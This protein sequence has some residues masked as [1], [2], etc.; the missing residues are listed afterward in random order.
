VKD[1]SHSEVAASK[2]PPCCAP[3]AQHEGPA[4]P[5]VAMVAGSEGRPAEQMILIRDG[6]FLMGSDD[7]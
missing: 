4:E 2:R 3:D 1:R 5:T 6:S 7:R